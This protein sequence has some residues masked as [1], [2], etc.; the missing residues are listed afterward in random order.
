MGGL[1]F[2][3]LSALKQAI[4]SVEFY[5]HEFPAGIKPIDY[6]ATRE[7]GILS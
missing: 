3:P 4:S 1:F 2:A 6:N 7:A 5:R